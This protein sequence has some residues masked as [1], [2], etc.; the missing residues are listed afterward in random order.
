MEGGFRYLY[1]DETITRFIADTS[2]SCVRLH[3]GLIQVYRPRVKSKAGLDSKSISV[4]IHSTGKT[5]QARGSYE[6]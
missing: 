4:I 2:R 3:I 5:V 1:S 6:S